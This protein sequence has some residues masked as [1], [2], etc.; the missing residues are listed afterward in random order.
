[1]HRAAPGPLVLIHPPAISRRYLKTK[2]LPY[3]MGVLA[4]FLRAQHV[5]VVQADFL[6]EY[7]YEAPGLS[8]YHDGEQTFSEEST[9]PFWRAATLMPGSPPS[10]TGSGSR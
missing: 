10:R 3:G 7:L 2:F 6:M 8:D 9:S 4:A 5:P 1:M